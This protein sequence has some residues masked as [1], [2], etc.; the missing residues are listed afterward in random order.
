MSAKAKTDI[1]AVWG[2]VNEERVIGDVPYLQL[3][4]KMS[5]GVM[6]YRAV[7]AAGRL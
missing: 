4:E 3:F 2:N 1:A 5:D 6:V 7:D